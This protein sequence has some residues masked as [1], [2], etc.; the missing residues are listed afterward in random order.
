MYNLNNDD[1]TMLK[2]IQIKPASNSISKNE[3]V[4]TINLNKNTL[5]KNSS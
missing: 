5:A 2:K 1:I 3:S 4:T